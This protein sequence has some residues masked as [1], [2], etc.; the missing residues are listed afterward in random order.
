MQN[1]EIEATHAQPHKQEEVIE[2]RGIQMHRRSQRNK[3]KGIKG[4]G[5]DWFKNILEPSHQRML[6]I[7]VG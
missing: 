2:T 4:T 5:L 7:L 6:G 1:L 3:K